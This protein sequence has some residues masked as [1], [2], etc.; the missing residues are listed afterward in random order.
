MRCTAPT[1]EHG[2]LTVHCAPD[3]LPG[4]LK[5][6]RDDTRCQFTTLVD[7][8]GVDW[9]ERE[10]RFELVYH[11]LSMRQ[12]QRVRVKTRCA[13]TRWRP[14]GHR[15]FPNADW[16]RARDLRPVWRAVLRAPGSAPDPDRLRLPRASAAQGLSRPRAMSS[17]AMTRR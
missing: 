6:L 3:G 7:I 11:L 8:C 13:R 1:V 12:N 2:E 9:P 10:K 17:C 5:F 14:I 15:V 4:F 16:Y